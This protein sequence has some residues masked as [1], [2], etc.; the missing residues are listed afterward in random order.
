MCGE[1]GEVD[2]LADLAPSTLAGCTTYIGKGLRV[3]YSQLKNLEPLRSLRHV[4]GFLHVD[5]C[6]ELLSLTGLETL[7]RVGSLSIHHA[8]QLLGVHALRSLREVDGD[9]ILHRLDGLI[10]LRGLSRLEAV[11]GRLYLRDLES[12]ETLAGLDGLRTVGE[13]Q[14]FNN[15]SLRSLEGLPQLER[16]AGRLSITWNPHLPQSEIDAFLAR[17]EVGGPVVVENNKP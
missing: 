6:I 16:V 11:G 15:D 3:R 1:P 4:S 8:N 5:Y 14:I 2:D 13:L 12:I 10:S 17:V 7:E 9:L